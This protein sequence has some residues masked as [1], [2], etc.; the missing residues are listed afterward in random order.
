VFDPN[1]GTKTAFKAAVAGEYRVMV[2]AVGKD[3]KGAEVKGEAMA[4]F[5]AYPDVSDEML[6][7][8]ADHEFL[9]S[10]ATSGGG[11]LMRLD[12]LP[13]YF[14]ELK[15]QPLANAKPKPRYLPDWRRNHS[16]GFL[17]GWLIAF[18]VVVGLEWGLRR[19]WGM[20]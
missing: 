8:A 6:R 15:G 7:T 18:V 17:T 5:F 16:G 10:L 14:K 4:S 9:K 1:V 2:S 13:N 19:L 3:S 12:D 20:V 11:Q